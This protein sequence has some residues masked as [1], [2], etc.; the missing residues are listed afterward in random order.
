MSR[1][2]SVRGA[3]RDVPETATSRASLPHLHQGARRH[4]VHVLEAGEAGQDP[5]RVVNRLEGGAVG[6]G[7]NGRNREQCLVLAGEDQPVAVERE[8]ERGIAHPVAGEDHAAIARVPQGEG[9]L[10]RDARQPLLTVGLPELP[11]EHAVARGL[12]RSPRHGP[13]RG[14]APF[15]CR[16]SRRTPP[17]PRAAAP[18]RPPS[19]G[20]RAI[21][22]RRGSTPP[23]PAPRCSSLAPMARSSPRSAPPKMPYTASTNSSNRCLCA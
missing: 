9:E 1:L 23:T 10:A 17:R 11:R 21:R 4:G 19:R 20:R 2:V 18:P 15:D 6:D 14:R 12:R 16:S 13:G 8:V 22:P 5:L 7:G 3:D